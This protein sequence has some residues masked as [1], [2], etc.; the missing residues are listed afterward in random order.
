MDTGAF[1]KGECSYR[2]YDNSWNG[3]VC[4]GTWKFS[5]TKTVVIVPSE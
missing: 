2:D 1:I 3:N 5:A 4:S